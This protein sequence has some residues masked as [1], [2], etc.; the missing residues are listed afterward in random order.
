MH[1]DYLSVHVGRVLGRINKTKTSINSLSIK[2]CK[3]LEMCLIPLIIDKHLFLF[4]TTY[5]SSL[6]CSKQLS[7]N[8][9]ARLRANC[10]YNRIFFFLEY[11]KEIKKH[12][13]MQ[14]DMLS[15]NDV[16]YISNEDIFKYK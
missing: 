7:Y 13:S 14:N 16:T 9:I 2:H 11:E 6:S 4:P 8:T 15:I 12:L 3:R 1:V 5:K 10:V